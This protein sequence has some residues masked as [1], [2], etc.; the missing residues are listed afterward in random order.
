M[1]VFVL[2]FEALF[3]NG[4]SVAFAE[5]LADGLE[6]GQGNEQPL[7]VELMEEGGSTDVIPTEESSEEQEGDKEKTPESESEKDAKKA[8]EQEAEKDGEKTDD[9]KGEE[10]KSDSDSSDVKTDPKPETNTEPAESEPVVA[11]AWDWTGKTDN[12]TLSSPDGLA[13]DAESLEELIGTLNL[14]FKLDPAL[15]GVDTGDH[16]T[17]VPDDTFTVDLPDGI[18]LSDE[19]ITDAEKGTF[20]IFQSD[21]EG[22]P[23]TVKIA[24]G[25]I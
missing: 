17:V 18:T 24:E 10:P 22:N 6:Q 19:M 7:E 23:T 4:V 12:P 9:S 3:N 5:A 20:D 21:A 8:G 14:T 25:A 2:T 13:L 1:L 11:D 15:D 16:T